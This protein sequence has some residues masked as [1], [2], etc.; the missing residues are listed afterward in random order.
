MPIQ[1]D[2]Q[3]PPELVQAGRDDARGSA[4][5]RAPMPS[6]VPAET[7]HVVAATDDNYAQHLTV[8]LMSLFAS[9]RSR[10]VQVHVL[11]PPSFTMRGHVEDALKA[12]ASRVEFISV[13]DSTVRQL[14]TSVSLPPS[15]YYRVLVGE[16][17]P[18]SVRRIVY[19]DCDLLVRSDLADMWDAPLGNNI[20]A[21]CP[22]T[23]GDAGIVL[24]VLDLPKTALYFNS[25]VMLI[26][27]DRWRRENVGQQVIDFAREHPDLLTWGDQC[28]LNWVLRDRWKPL[29][30][31]W[32]VQTP[33]FG[34]GVKGDLYFY[35]PAPPAA[36]AGRIIHFTGW[37]RPWNYMSEHPFKPL[38][39]HYLAQT[40]WRGRRPSD[41]Y[42]HNMVCKT[43][44]RHAPG[45]LPYYI[46]LRRII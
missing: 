46:R 11:V 20:A 38:Y 37:G 30:N 18:A 45:L 35:K 43:L 19:L 16:I 36:M 12:D 15:S 13:A 9:C 33:S 8:M 42:P 6:A 32:N 1:T 40:F 10:P 14:K 17:L 28:A 24:H 4:S 2:D 7:I 39:Q 34:C 21:A 29:G 26:D 44:K 5:G 22:D 3:L 31:E 25:G 23:G 27:L 41:K